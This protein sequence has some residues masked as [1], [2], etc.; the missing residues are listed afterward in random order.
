MQ[1]LPLYLTPT[2][3]KKMLD[4]SYMGNICSL[5]LASVNCW[6]DNVLIRPSI[7]RHCIYKTNL[8]MHTSFLS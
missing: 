5:L 2:S 7:F 3:L 1:S 4:N 8:L 6:Q